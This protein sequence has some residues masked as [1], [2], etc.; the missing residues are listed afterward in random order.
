MITLKERTAAETAAR[1]D[2]V[3]VRE[4]HIWPSVEDCKRHGFEPKQ[5]YHVVSGDGYQH[6]S[7]V[8]IDTL[9]A[10]GLRVEV[11]K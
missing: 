8:T 10:L 11:V 4:A 7:T 1:G 2:M 6:G 9:L 5:F 3:Q